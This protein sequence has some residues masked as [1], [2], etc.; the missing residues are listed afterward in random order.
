MSVLLLIGIAVFL[1]TFSGKLFQK[2]RVPQVIGYIIVGVVL[3]DSLLGLWEPEHL[4]A[5]APLIDFTLGVIGF[6]IG[7]ELKLEVFKKYGRSIYLMLIG[8]GMLAFLAVAALV[9][10]VTGKVYLG[11]LLGAIASATDPASTVNVL[12]EYRARGPLTTTVTSIVALD[13]GLALILYGLVSVF[14]KSMIAGSP[15]SF[16]SSIVAPLL[17][18]GECFIL[19][20]IAGFF[21]SKL[22]PRIKEKSF[23]LSFV[24]GLVA[25]TVGVSLWL[26]LDLI[27]STMIMGAVLSNSIPKISETIYKQLKEVTTPL[28]IFFFIIVGIS[29]DVAIFLR[30][31][32]FSIIIVYLAGR[33]LG[34][35]FGA[36]LGA[37]IA[38]AGKSVAAYSGLCLFT[39]GGVAMGLAMSIAHNLDYLGAE[40]RNTGVIVVS[41]V[42]ATSFIV[43]LIGPLLVKFGATR[44]GEAGRN[45]TEEDIIEISTVRNF[46]QKDFSLVREDA[47]LDKIMETIKERESYHFPVVDKQGSLVGLI[48]LG[49][50]RNVF[51]ERDL[52]HVI[53][54]RDVALPA[55]KVLYEN[56]PLRKAFEIFDKRQ[57]DYLPVVEDNG[58][59]RVVGI[60]EYHEL[61]EAVN[62]TLLERQ[63]VLDAAA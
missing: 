36:M 7:F 52:D 29:L 32:I 50:L 28:Y 53:L 58:I 5:L 62:R 1:G 37:K 12:W 60:V 30:V 61:I 39:Q 20:G 48:S 3:G 6:L 27:L 63:R 10:L 41:V 46:M 42:A 59:R 38:K 34:K 35:V 14:S 24:L 23:V 4:K 57:I 21:I 56:E 16:W 8:E 15:F 55:E 54:A 44:S 51:R 25:I 19:G 45:V 17:E 31:A 2:L 22:L 13:D 40:G 11:L 18:I 47:T 49:A 43:Q 9:T 33:S 26:H